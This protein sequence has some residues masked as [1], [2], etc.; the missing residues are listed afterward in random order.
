MAFRQEIKI[1]SHDANTFLFLIEEM[2]SKGGKVLKGYP[3]LSLPYTAYFEFINKDYIQ[4]KPGV[5][6][7]G[8]KVME[9]AVAVANYTKEQLEEMDWDAFRAVCKVFEIKGRERAV[10]IEQYLKAQ[11]EGK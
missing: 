7:L 10:M 3:F 6:D 9:D 4:S 11:A 1:T 2:V 8:R 5:I